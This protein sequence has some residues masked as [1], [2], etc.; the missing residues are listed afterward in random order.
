M[1]N[2][3]YGT[4]SMELKKIR[5]LA[6]VFLSVSFIVLPAAAVSA[7]T[8][9]IPR[10]V[11]FGNAEKTRP[12]L[13]P[14]GKKLAYLA[15]Y[16]SVLN[17]W[18]RELNGSRKD[19][20]VTREANAVGDFYWASDSRHLL[21]LQDS[22]GDENWHLYDKDIHTGVSNSLTPFDGVR[23]EILELSKK[24]PRE[25][26]ITMNKKNPDVFDAYRFDL[27]QKLFTLL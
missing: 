25:I 1:M 27:K 8:P 24:N 22:N 19:R 5:R 15:P 6:L 12:Q 26:L 7:E 11:L 2:S 14:D 3:V 20:P 18:L 17:I 13:S 23:V 4:C 16:N 10:R 21:Y 9:L